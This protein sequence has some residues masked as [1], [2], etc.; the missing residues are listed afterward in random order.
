MFVCADGVMLS[1]NDECD[2]VA[3]CAGGEDEADCTK[4]VCK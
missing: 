2:G 4:L 3:D 1:E